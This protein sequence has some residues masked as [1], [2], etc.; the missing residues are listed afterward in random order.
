METNLTGK[1]KSEELEFVV[2]AVNRHIVTY[3]AHVSPVS[4]IFFYLDSDNPDFVAKFDDLRQEL[5]PRGFIPFINHD[6][7]NSITVSKRPPASYRS[8]AVNLTLFFLTLASTIYV[9]TMYSYAYATT[10]AMR[11]LYGFLFFSAPL[12][13]ILGLH[14]LGHYFVAKHYKVKAS[15]PFFIPFPLTIGTFGAFISL[16]DPIPNKRA[17]T[18]IGAAG[19]IVGFLTSVP[20]LFVA[21]YLSGV[22]HTVTTPSPGFTI[23]FPYIYHLLGLP[24]LP[25]AMSHTFPMVFSVWVGIFATAMNLLPVSQLDGGHIIRGIMG[26]ASNYVGYL[27]VMLLIFISFFYN[28]D[29]W[30]FLALF[31]IFM[32]VSHPPPLDDYSKLKWI[33]VAIGAF[34]L[35]M[36]IVSFTA[37]PIST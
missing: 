11:I 30:L 35:F 23:N 17:M 34:A 13:L 2:E 33:D 24:A 12:M 1:V 4:V 29:G 28:Y 22:I 37:V 7:E 8:N 14:E 9:G 36:F 27:I 32:G 16:R 3:E 21:Q 10:T 6:A 19:P 26:K 25:E 20:L 18:E 5:V 31:V 15:F